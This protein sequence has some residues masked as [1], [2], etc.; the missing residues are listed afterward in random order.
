M[1]SSLKSTIRQVIPSSLIDWFLWKR[2]ARRFSDEEEKL[3][4]D[5][6]SDIDQRQLTLR[7]AESR[8]HLAAD[9]AAAAKYYKHRIWLTK[10]IADA[11]RLDLHREKGLD[12][13]DIGCGPGWF[14]TV[15]THLGHNCVGMDL[16]FEMMRSGD[17]A[18]YKA[19]PEILDCTSRII[20][21]PVEA[22]IPNPVEGQFDLITCMLI[23]FDG[24]WQETAWGAQEWTYFLDD[25][26][27]LLAPEGRL[28][29][30]FNKKPEIHQELTYYDRP[31]QQ[32]LSSRGE[33][34]G[35]GQV[36]IRKQLQ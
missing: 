7:L 25:M 12:L 4:G 2:A 20:R 26:D 33:M 30:Q 8:K 21:E 22:F 27:R 31:T 14:L 15:A 35:N 6:C 11:T 18:V 3:F 32:I 1:F 5:I 28:F 36:V 9:P 13:L 24:H 23:C 10:S 34:K 19:I 17:R 29:L 16:P